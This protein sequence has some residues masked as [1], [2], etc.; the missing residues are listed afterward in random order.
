MPTAPIDPFA[1]DPHWIMVNARYAGDAIIE[2]AEADSDDGVTDWHWFGGNNWGFY[3]PKR[4]RAR[5]VVNASIVTV[6]CLAFVGLVQVG[7]GAFLIA[8]ALH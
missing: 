6:A 1:P 2:Q 8:S 3:A 5:V 4:R 7:R